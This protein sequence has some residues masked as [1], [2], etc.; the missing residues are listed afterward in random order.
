MRVVLREVLRAGAFG[1]SISVT[2]LAVRDCGT[3]GVVGPRR[4][5][6]LRPPDWVFGVVWPCLYVTT[7]IAWTV[8]GTTADL[9]LA[10]VTFLCCAWLVVYVC[11]RERAL[12]AATLALTA[13]LV[14]TTAVT[15]GGTV[16]GLL[17]PLA[18]WT[19]FA[20]Y[21]NV[22]DVLWPST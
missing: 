15:F 5:I 22:Y 11:M 14:T 10:A 13:T 1:V 6:P 19:A 20:T 2:S 18:L 7:G 21:L 17:A 3:L 4:E 8:A 16:G 9:P 12:A